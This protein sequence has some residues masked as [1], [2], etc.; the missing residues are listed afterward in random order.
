MRAESKYRLVIGDVNQTL[1][2]EAKDRL[3]DLIIADPPFGISFSKSSHEYGAK[4]YDL[5]KDDFTPDSY[6]DF[7]K[8]WI[9]S[10]YNA[11]KPNGSLYIISGWTNLQY[12]LNAIKKT[13][14]HMLNHAI[15]HFSWGVYTKRRFVTSHYHIVLLVKNKKNYQ[16]YKQKHYDEDVFYWKE[17]NRGNDP[18]RIKGH[19]CQ[20]PIVLLEKL[21]LTSSA[22]GD[23]VGDVFSGSGGTILAS[24]MTDRDVIGFE[25][26]KEYESIIKQ[27]A[28]FGSLLEKDRQ[29]G[30]LDQYLKGEK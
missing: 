6:L 7:S 25:I 22:K 27:K 20:L 12:I 21:I 29:A 10:C 3:F 24:R 9:K 16:F 1:P 11:L 17:Y 28:K 8:K 23:L 5:Y 13:D 15:W 18:H 14:F 26:R 30:I 19:P 2:I 4:E